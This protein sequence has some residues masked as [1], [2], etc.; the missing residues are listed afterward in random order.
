MKRR[1]NKRKGGKYNLFFYSSGGRKHLQYL[2]YFK[3]S[4]HNLIKLPNMLRNK[5]KSLKPMRKK[6]KSV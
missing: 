4:I 5:T 3:Y 2:K 6:M 1:K